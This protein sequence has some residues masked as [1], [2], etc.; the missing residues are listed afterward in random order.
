M[1]S[2]ST[3]RSPEPPMSP[4]AMDIFDA[5]KLPQPRVTTPLPGATTNGGGW[6]LGGT[7]QSQ[8]MVSEKSNNSI[9]ARATVKTEKSTGSYKSLA[10]NLP[11]PSLMN[12]DEFFKSTYPPRSNVSSRQSSVRRPHDID[13][14]QPIRKTPSRSIVNA[15]PREPVATRSVTTDSLADF[16]KST[17]PADFGSGGADPPKT[18]KKSKSGFFRRMFGGANKTPPMP[19]RSS[20]GRFTPI[21]I[22]AD[23]R[24]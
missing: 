18:L 11:S 8:P 9:H 7:Q 16:L 22:P 19:R 1:T 15:A 6:Q 17:G 24:G 20:S 23:I 10:V 4:R 3:M 13:E 12:S 21:T 14:I 5:A 2:R